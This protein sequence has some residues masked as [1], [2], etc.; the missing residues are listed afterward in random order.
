V[1]FDSRPPGADVVVSGRTRCRTPCALRL[2]PGH[3]RIVLRMSG[4]RPWESDLGVRLG[5]DERVEASLVSS[6]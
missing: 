4:Y 1:S 2:D 3:Y 6:H 5:T